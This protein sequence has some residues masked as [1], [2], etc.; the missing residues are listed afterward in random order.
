[1]TSSPKLL[2]LLLLYVFI[3]LASGHESIINDNHLNLPSDG[4]WRTDEE[5]KS[6]YLQWSAE[7]GKTNN[8]NNGIINQQ[9]ERFNILKDNLRFIDLHNENNKNA[10]YKLGLTIFADLTNDEYRRLYLGARTEPARRMAKAK[11]VNQKFSAAVNKEALPETV[12]WRQKGA[13]NAI[14]NQ[15][16]C[17]SCWAFSTAAVVEGINKIVTGELISLSEQ[18]L[19][20]CDKSYNQGCNGGLMDYAFQFIM[21]NG[22]LNTEQD[23]PYRGSD[24]KCNSLLKNSKVVTIDGYEDVPTNDETALKRA[25]SYQPVSVAID[26]GGRVFQH[27]QSGIFTGECGTEMDHAVVAVGYGS[28]NGVDYWIVRNSWGQKWGEDGYIRIE[29]NLASSKSGKCGIAIEASYPVKYSPNPVRGIS[30]V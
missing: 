13:V 26:A 1:M 3:S 9:D 21:K 28:E 18:E 7:H 25:V 15:G 24:G 20:D 2:S 10:T 6:I 11:N 27:Y 19:V 17:G 16:T 22:G 23:Y 5:V 14:K 4:S 8:N 12:D 30:S 29:R